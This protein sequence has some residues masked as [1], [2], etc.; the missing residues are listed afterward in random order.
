MSNELRL[1]AHFS[2]ALRR[3]TWAGLVVLLA[4][5]ASAQ[6]QKEEKSNMQVVGY[7][8]L[9]AR[10]SYQPTIHQQG[11]RWIAYIGHH[12]GSQMNPMTGQM[13][14]N[15]TSLLDVTDAAHPKYLAHIPGE[16]P[17]GGNAETGGAQMARVCDGSSLPHADKSKVYMLRTFGG[18]IET[19]PCDGG[20]Q[21]LGGY[22]QELVGM[23]HGD[24]L[25]C[26]GSARV[27]RPAHDADLRS[28]RSGESGV[29]PEFWLAGATT[30]FDRTG[31]D[32]IARPL[33]HGSEQQ[34]RVLRVRNEWQ[35]HRADCR[36]Q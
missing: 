26:L 28:Q 21:R 3:A 4:I 5:A 25:P 14:Y 18:S 1:F 16:P 29:H 31:A 22:P 19:E 10:S 11:Q 23:R 17:K 24:R 34:S 7:N 35:R 36:S 33:L 8:D 12:G 6:P 30:G 2:A 27:A 32:R 13:E 15:G 9:Q 20:L